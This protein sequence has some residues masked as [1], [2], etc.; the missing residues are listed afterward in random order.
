MSVIV[1]LNI[2]LLSIEY[3][4]QSVIYENIHDL[5]STTVITIFSAEIFWKLFSMRLHFFRNMWNIH[6]L[7][8]TILCI[9]GFKFIL[10]LDLL[11]QLVLFF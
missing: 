9:I 1:S 5:I 4:N 6:N 11:I 10:I 3:F 2:I 7:F 8:V